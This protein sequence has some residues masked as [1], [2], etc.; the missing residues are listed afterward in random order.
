MNS[1]YSQRHSER[2]GIRQPVIA[3]HFSEK[4]QC[5]LVELLLAKCIKQTHLLQAY[6]LA[7]WCFSALRCGNNRC[8]YFASASQLPKTMLW[9]ELTE[10]LGCLF[11]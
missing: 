4:M 8:K 7:A 10:V 5:N 2:M 9:N 1:I 6:V 3:V 11:R